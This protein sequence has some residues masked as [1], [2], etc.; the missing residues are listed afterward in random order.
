[1]SFNKVILSGYVG[2]VG[3]PRKSKD[4]KSWITLSLATDSGYAGNKKTYW[5][6]LMA[7]GKTA[8]V[9]EK[10]VGKGSQIIVDGEITYSQWEDKNGVKKDQTTIMVSSVSFVG[11]KPEKSNHTII[12]GSLEHDEIPF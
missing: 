9:I 3:E 8:D 2:K 5:H 11:K 1:M 10:Y 7:F 12:E 4:D 6:N